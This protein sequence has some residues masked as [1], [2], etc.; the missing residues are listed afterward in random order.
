VTDLYRFRSMGCEIVVGGATRAEAREVEELFAE[1]DRVFSRFRA[2]SE[3][4]AVNAAGGT[5]LVSELFAATLQIALEVAAATDGLVDPT[6]GAAIVAAGYD[7]DFAQID[8]QVTK[9]HL[10]ASAGCWRSVRVAGRLVGRPVGTQLDLNGVVKSLAVDDALTLLSGPGFVSA[11]GD[12]G[13]NA[14]VDVA[15]PAGGAIRVVLGGIA[16]SGTVAR[17]WGREQ[18]HLID[19]ATGEPSRSP[20]T[21]V[22]VVGG[23]CLAADVCAKAAFL[24]GHDGPEWLEARGLPGRFLADDVVATNEPWRAALAG[25]LA[26]I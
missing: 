5:V 17:R 20:W 4:N 9:C 3:L 10:A 14:P 22:T 13:A 12:L 23:T 25:E 15:L 7:R 21:Q 1:R 18:H 8:D 11:G 16:T 6:L 2:D 19:P 24:L 26:C